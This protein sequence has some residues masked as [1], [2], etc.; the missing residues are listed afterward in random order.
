VTVFIIELVN[1]I[2]NL[3][4][5]EYIQSNINVKRLEYLLTGLVFADDLENVLFE[6]GSGDELVEEVITENQ[7]AEDIEQKED[8]REEADALDIDGEYDYISN[9]ENIHEENEYNRS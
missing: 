6:F 5:L 8:A 7:T 4:N 1:Y 3:F 9:Y 2:F